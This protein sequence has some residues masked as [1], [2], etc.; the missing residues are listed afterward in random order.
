ML[1]GD[2]PEPGPNVHHLLGSDGRCAATR[3]EAQPR[4]AGTATLA[5]LL[6]LSDDLL[7]V[8]PDALK[9][10]QVELTMVGGR[11]VHDTRRF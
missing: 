2:R 10:V 6:V 9:D 8:P 4:N 7:R 5:D 11:I 1:V 3:P